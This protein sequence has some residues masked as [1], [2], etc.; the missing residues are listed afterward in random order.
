MKDMISKIISIDKK[1]REALA[2]TLKLKVDSMQKVNE[3]RAQKR[4]EHID[5]AKRN[6]KIIEL[7][8]RELGNARIIDIENTYK[9]VSENLD[10]VYGENSEDWVHQI[11]QRVKEGL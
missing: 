10:K 3:L 8:E 11:V 2:K 7:R 5:K 9:G 6:I 1:S 4:A